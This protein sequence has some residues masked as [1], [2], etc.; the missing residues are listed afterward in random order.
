[1]RPPSRTSSD[2]TNATQGLG[3]PAP[4]PLQLATPASSKFIEPRKTTSFEPV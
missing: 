1:L 2:A 3:L 4:S